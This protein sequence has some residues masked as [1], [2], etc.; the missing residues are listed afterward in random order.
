MADSLKLQLTEEGTEIIYTD[1]FVV[2]MVTKIDAM[3]YGKEANR[4]AEEY[5]AIVRNSVVTQ[6]EK[7]SLTNL[8]LKLGMIALILGGLILLI[9]LINRVFRYFRGH[10]T[11]HRERYLKGLTINKIKLFSPEQLELVILRMNG[12]LRVIVILLSVYLSLP[13]LFSIFPDQLDN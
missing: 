13:L 10:I 7:M 8:L 9:L 12:S 2:M 3:Y 4:L 5:L 6:R 11:S 1:G